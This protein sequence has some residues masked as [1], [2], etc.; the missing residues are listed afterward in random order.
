[1]YLHSNR[2]LDSPR[3]VLVI[4][5]SLIF[6]FSL[7]HEST[8]VY[9]KVT[10]KILKNISE[11]KCGQ[12]LAKQPIDR[13]VRGPTAR[14]GE[15]PW[16]VSIQ[17]WNNETNVWIPNCG[18]SAL[19]ETV[20]VTA[21]HCFKLLDDNSSLVLRLVAGCRDVMDETDTQC[22]R[23]LVNKSNII[24]HPKWDAKTFINDLTIIELSKKLDFRVDTRN[25]VV[26]ICLPPKDFKWK[27]HYGQLVY[28]AGWGQTEA[29]HYS[30]D[31]NTV[32]VKI[33]D[34]EVCKNVYNP[35]RQDPYGFIDDMYICAVGNHGHDSCQGD[36]GGPLMLKD[37]GERKRMMMIG[38]TSFNSG[39]CGKGEK[40]PGAYLNIVTYLDWIN[41]FLEQ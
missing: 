2:V 18:A 21:S 25:P 39:V 41:G 35:S 40:T 10:Y 5:F 29:S 34:P 22:Q 4:S 36:S 31:L 1:M 13:I 30:D 24:R 3:V 33:T 23:F 17:L 28:L 20:L 15:Y 19:S 27:E 37:E 11:V 9:T 32:A 14:K 38:V 26:P 7:V 8:E 16:M 6:L 12:Q